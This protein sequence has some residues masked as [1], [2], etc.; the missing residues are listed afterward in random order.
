M[1]TLTS[2]F[3]L[4]SRA[5]SFV[6]LTVATLANAIS[7]T[8]ASQPGDFVSAGTNQIFTRVMFATFQ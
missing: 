8:L 6:E 7:I 5:G 4:A 2:W 3:V 1:K